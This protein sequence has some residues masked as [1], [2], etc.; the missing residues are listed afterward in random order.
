M[1]WQ[2]GRELSRNCSGPVGAPRIAACLFP[3]KKGA[4]APE[5]FPLDSRQSAFPH[6]AEAVKEL[7]TCG[8]ER[9]V[10]MMLENKLMQILRFALNHRGG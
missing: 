4:G 8:A 1:L 5:A 2:Q 9:S 6:A 7:K 10:C 3:I